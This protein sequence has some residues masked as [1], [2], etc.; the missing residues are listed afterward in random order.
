MRL[1]RRNLGGA[2]RGAARA[3]QVR[4]PHHGAG[5]YSRRWR[6]CDPDRRGNTRVR[7][8]TRAGISRLP[9]PLTLSPRKWALRRSSPRTAGMTISLPILRDLQA[10]GASFIICHASR[11]PDGV[12]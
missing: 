12:P 10:G 1:H 5:R 4:W 7:A 3:G 11:L 8:Q 9:M 6:R 2:D